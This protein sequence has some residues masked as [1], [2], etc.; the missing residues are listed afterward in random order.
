MAEA[1]NEALADDTIPQGQDAEATD[2]A[3]EGDQGQQEGDNAPAEIPEAVK[4]LAAKYGWKPQ[5]EWQ[6]EGWTD[7]DAFLEHQ[8]ERGQKAKDQ[9]KA[10]NKRAKD[11]E[12]QLRET[13]ARQLD[14]ELAE[15]VEANNLDRVKDITSRKQMLNE[16]PAVSDFRD[17]N[18]WFGT[19]AR[20]TALVKVLDA[21]FAAEAGGP[22]NVD[23][24]EH[25]RR[26]EQEV[27]ET[28]PE[29]AG[30]AKEKVTI[31]RRAAPLLAKATSATRSNDGR[32]N[33][34]NLTA[35]ELS[36]FKQ[37]KD[38]GMVTDKKAYAKML[39]T[40]KERENV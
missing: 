30:K 14:D 4:A 17:R 32:K 1:T 5:E 10:A 39:N 34:A 21:E 13:T 22:Q 6:G 40:A 24:V 23:P 19:H 28:F 35:E 16:P 37:L 3:G 36:A 2:N 12:R 27:L 31:Q 38:A 9:S 26:I 7:A 29:L 25:M 33:E 8:L 20:A 15:A 11:L 18:A